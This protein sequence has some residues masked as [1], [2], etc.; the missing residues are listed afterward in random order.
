MI[1]A[2]PLPKPP[3][4]PRRLKRDLHPAGSARNT[5][6]PAPERRLLPD[7]HEVTAVSH[8]HRRQVEPAIVL[9]GQTGYGD[10]VAAVYQVSERREGGHGAWCWVARG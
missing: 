5:A 6:Q 1:A 7:R 4:Q 9:A 3:R 8:S 10:A 2:P